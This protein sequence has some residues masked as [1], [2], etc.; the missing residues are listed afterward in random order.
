MREYE[1]V[2]D[3]ALLYCSFGRNSTR[4]WGMA[5][6]DAGS[7]NSVVVASADEAVT[8]SRTPGR[9]LRRG[10]Q[11][12]IVT[13]GGGGWGP[14]SERDPLDVADDI[15]DGLRDVA[16]AERLYGVV[17]DSASGAV[18]EAETQRRRGAV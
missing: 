2:S 12:R 7:P 4:P 18:D 15:R 5:G 3:E 17:F 1:I 16:E 8:L 14:P 10:D 6:G 13:G 11:V 9:A